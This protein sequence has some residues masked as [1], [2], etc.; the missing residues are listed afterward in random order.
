MHLVGGC[1]DGAGGW[2]DACTW[3]RRKRG[4]EGQGPEKTRLSRPAAGRACAVIDGATAPP[5]ESWRLADSH[6][7]VH[8]LSST[9]RPLLQ[10][11]AIR[12]F[13]RSAGAPRCPPPHPGRR[14]QGLG[15]R[16]QWHWRL[17]PRRVAS[18]PAQW[19][20][21]RC[22]GSAARLWQFRY[23]APTDVKGRSLAGARGCGAFSRAPLASGWRPRRT[24]P[25]DGGPAGVARGVDVRAAGG[26]HAKLAGGKEGK[27]V[28]EGRPRGDRAREAPGAPAGVPG[29]GHAR[30]LRARATLPKNG[31]RH[32]EWACSTKRGGRLGSAGR[33]RGRRRH[34][35][36]GARRRAEAPCGMGAARAAAQ[37]RWHGAY[38]K[39]A[40]TGCA[41]RC[42]KRRCE[43]ARAKTVPAAGGDCRPARGMGV[44]MGGVGWGRR[45]AGGGAR[46]RP[47]LPACPDAGPV[48]RRRAGREGRDVGGGGRG[49]LP[50]GRQGRRQLT[51]PFSRG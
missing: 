51:P 31:G 29:R 41:G 37:R 11:R 44:G 47:Q 26:P 22:A 40:A 24:L 13:S 1:D 23:C 20:L 34:W 2:L 49:L 9:V 32:N 33:W 42:T 12:A 8:T 14:R 10:Q 3:H 38:Q 43:N 25:P 21:A 39:A 30:S 6:A 19:G 18:T 16:R 4:D 17:A 7:H 50:P 15:R 27:G 48:A 28:G 45:D 35:V 46:P 5:E 36:P